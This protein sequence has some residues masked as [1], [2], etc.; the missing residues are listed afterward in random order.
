MRI[1]CVL[2]LSLLACAAGWRALHEG[3]ARFWE[4]QV[5]TAEIRSETRLL[6][7]W[8]KAAEK[9]PNL[10]SFDLEL[11]ARGQT[12]LARKPRE[13]SDGYVH[14]RRAMDAWRAAAKQRPA[15]PYVWAQLADAK[16]SAGA[17]D[18]EFRDA[19]RRA[20]RFGP[21]E[22]RVLRALF[23]IS[24]FYDARMGDALRVEQRQVVRTLARRE[25]AL[26]IDQTSRYHRLAWLC[27]Q[28][29]AAEAPRS[30]CAQRGFTEL[31]VEEK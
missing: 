18:A 14:S 25:P 30:E 8:I 6:P 3:R 9:V 19:Y 11:F 24:L 15:W 22:P 17:F 2:I 10:P 23:R 16:A 26:L 1:V 7:E 4:R 13:P 29:F 27:T 20:L 21:F 12:L 5:V 31:P 28:T